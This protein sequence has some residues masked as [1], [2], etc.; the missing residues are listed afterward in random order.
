MRFLRLL[1]RRRRSGNDKTAPP[2]ESPDDASDGSDDSRRFKV[3]FGA[4]DSG[5]HKTAAVE[6]SEQRC[7][8][9]IVACDTG[10]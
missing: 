4:V 3:G 10:H 8:H 7:R 5:C 2:T 6:G 9:K 1:V